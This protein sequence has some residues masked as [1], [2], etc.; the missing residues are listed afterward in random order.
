MDSRGTGGAVRGSDSDR[1][2]AVRIA[3][4]A[5]L[6]AG[7]ALDAALGDP[8]RLHPVAG[9]GR[10][11]AALE[12]RLYAPSRRA[13]AVYA[14]AAIGAPVAAAAVAAG[15]TRRRPWARAALVAGATW[16]VLGART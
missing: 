11:A 8:R 12:R 2:R 16:A 9:F 5:G 1:A 13:G 4:A 14:V 7:F 15:L 3:G 6:L 10:A